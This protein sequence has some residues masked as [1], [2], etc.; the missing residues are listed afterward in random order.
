MTPARKSQIETLIANDAIAKG[1]FDAGRYGDCAL[2]LGQIAPPIRKPL[3]LSEM[4]IMAIYADHPMTG[5]TICQTIEGVSQGN[6]IVARMRRFLG[7]GV[8]PESLPD[9]SL[10]G[11]RQAL[12]AP[13]HLGGLG[14][15]EQQAAPLLAA[16]Q[17]PDTFSGRD[18]E[19]L[20]SEGI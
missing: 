14:L 19:Q 1:Y 4:G 20:A 6:P 7:P 18:I 17:Q 5:E 16:G 13:I 11:I 8:G 9:F 10:P 12:T 2:R 15:T 3:P